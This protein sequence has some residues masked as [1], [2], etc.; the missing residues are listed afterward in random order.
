[1][2]AKD[3]PR[4]SYCILELVEWQHAEMNVCKTRL[5]H[6][7]KMLAQRVYFFFWQLALHYKCAELLISSKTL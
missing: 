4:G 2:E 5:F 3:V 6:L 7:G 1:M